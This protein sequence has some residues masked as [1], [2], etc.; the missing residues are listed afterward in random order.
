ME[1]LAHFFGSLH[2]A[3]FHFAVA[4]PIFAFFAVL[5]HRFWNQPWLSY[6]AA[7]LWV[8]GCLAGLGAMV[9]G[10]LFSLQLGMVT[11]WAFFPPES[12]MK[13]HLRDHALLGTLSVLSSFFSLWAAARILRKKPW[14][15]GLQL[16]LGFTL[17]VLFGLTGHEG[18]E[19]V[20][21]SEDNPLIA[22]ISSTTTPSDL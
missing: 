4:C 11:Q 14:P 2:P 20:Y 15:I 3:L 5:G 9:S 19:M 6:S 13:G 12:S 16:F 1:V 8:F 17:A 10:H 18:G 21:G 7:S 22:P